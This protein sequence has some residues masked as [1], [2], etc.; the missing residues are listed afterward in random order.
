MQVTTTLSTMQSN[1]AIYLNR[2]DQSTNITLGINRAIDYYSSGN[3]FFF[4]EAIT[5]FST[6]INQES[7][8]S[9]DGVPT[10]IQEIDDLI[11]TQASTNKMPLTPRTYRWIKARNVAQVPGIPYDYAYYNSKFF[12]SLIPD[13]VYTMTLSYTKSYADL[14]AGSDHNDFTDNAASLIEARTCWWIYS[15]ILKNKDAAADAKAEELDEL[16]NAQAQTSD[17]VK[18]RKTVPTRF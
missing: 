18:S 7:Y 16:V 9:A 11:I 3:N 2:T 8:G 14:S 17:L 4:Q 10:N 13:Q 15:K 5:T 6:V 12:M 1:I